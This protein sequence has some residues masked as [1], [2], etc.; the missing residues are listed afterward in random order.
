VKDGDRP[1]RGKEPDPKRKRKPATSPRAVADGRSGHGTESIRP[2]LRAQL[3]LKELMQ[4]P[5][6]GFAGVERRAKPRS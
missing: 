5:Q 2:Y 6:L 1:T 3:K 4:G